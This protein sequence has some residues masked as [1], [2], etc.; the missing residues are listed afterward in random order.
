MQLCLEGPSSCLCRNSAFL[1]LDDSW[2]TIEAIV[3]EALIGKYYTRDT[4]IAKSIIPA[5][6][7]P[8]LDD[9]AI[10]PNAIDESPHG[11]SMAGDKRKRELESEDM[12]NPVAVENHDAAAGKEDEEPKAS[13]SKIT[14]MADK[15]ST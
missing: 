1:A 4:L 2:C 11:R 3:E 14:E 10:S 12:A 15:L 6:P 8:L 5:D 13:R 9:D 7:A